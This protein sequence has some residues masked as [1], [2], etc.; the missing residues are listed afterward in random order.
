M[1]RNGDCSV[2][3]KCRT[4]LKTCHLK[5]VSNSNSFP[6]SLVYLATPKTDPISVICIDKN[7][8]LLGWSDHTLMCRGSRKIEHFNVS[9]RSA[10]P[11]INLEGMSKEAFVGWWQLSKANAPTSLTWAHSAKAETQDKKV[12]MRIIRYI[13]CQITRN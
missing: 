4:T 6:T 5:L 9:R 3:E 12:K 7:K 1:F 10:Q 2:Y 11:I 8:Y 13:N